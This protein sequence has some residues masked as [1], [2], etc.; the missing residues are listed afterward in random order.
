MRFQSELELQIKSSCSLIYVVTYE[1]ERL[2][3][4][5]SE[6][7]SNDLSQV[8]FSWNFIEGFNNLKSNGADTPKNPLQALDFIESFA[9]D[10]DA[11]F[12]L[13]DFCTFLSDISISRK[14]RN[15]SRKLDLCNHVVIITGSDSELPNQLKY[16]TSFL[17][18]PLPDRYEIT[19]EL[20]RFFCL[21]RQPLSDELLNI[22]TTLCQGLS[23]GQ[24][25]KL[26]S[27]I[28]VKNQS[29]TPLPFEDISQEKQRNIKQTSF[30]EVL[31]PTNM[32][33]HNIGG[34]DNIRLWFEKRLEAFTLKSLNYGLCYPRGVLLLGIQGT[35]KSMTAKA[36]A[37]LWNIPLM[38][39]DV[40]RLF[41]G[42]VGKSESNVRY[43]IQIVEA[44]APC[45]LWIDEIDK[46]FTH[47]AAQGDGGT[48]GRVTGTLLTWLSEKTS[49]VFIVATANNVTS[50]PSEIIRKGRFDE[51]FFLD[52]PSFRERKKIFRFHLQKVRPNTWHRYNLDYLSKY[53]K[54][55]SGAEIEQTILEAMYTAFCQN[56]DF[57]SLDILD[58]M[59]SIIPLAFSD[60]ENVEQ[61]QRL[62]KLGKFRLASG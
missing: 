44:A 37:S 61:L 28:L 57:T 15:L 1:E 45:I 17:I 53:S 36:I 50:L 23:I 33:L 31:Y 14:I 49:P 11:I 2:E 35:G 48:S 39:L 46:F 6:I 30:L 22:L 16:I 5:I 13:K 56:R 8:I 43:V 51:I 27:K 29:F 40:G 9:E 24:I 3:N 47:G 21:T 26:L 10:S 54:L 32:S 4:M 20:K 62:A 34:I 38:R 52:L 7:S 12:I 58:A 41:A 55:F 25:R 19:I 60:S 18:M 42:I 59:E